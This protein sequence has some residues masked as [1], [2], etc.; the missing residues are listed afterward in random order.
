MAT[1]SHPA[2]PSR[3]YSSTLN[4]LPE[5]NL[6]FSAS[7]NPSVRESALQRQERERAERERA[8]PSP[9]G[10]SNPMSALSDEQREEVNEAVCI[11]LQYEVVDHI[12]QE[13]NGT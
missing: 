4:K 8:G 2:F 11:F 9:A 5:R 6:P 12:G 3:P 7:S 10:G 13:G 1:Q